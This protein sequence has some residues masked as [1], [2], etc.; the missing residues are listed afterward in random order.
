MLGLRTQ[1]TKKFINFMELI[2]KEAEKEDKVFFLEAGDGNEFETEE[3]EGEELTG[4]LI[5]SDKVEEFKSIWENEEIDDEW[6][7]FFTFVDWEESNGEIKVSFRA[8]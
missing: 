5:P 1:E 8:S 2:Q 6:I 4:W 7:D 3:M